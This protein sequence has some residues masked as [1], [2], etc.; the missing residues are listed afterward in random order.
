MKPDGRG[1]GVVPRGSSVRR[2]GPGDE[3]GLSERGRAA[4]DDAVR[5]ARQRDRPVDDWATDFDVLDPVYVADPFRVWD[6]LRTRCPVAHSGRRG[7]DW[8]PTRYEDVTAIAHDTEHFSSVD[9]IVIPLEVERPEEAILPF[10]FPPSPPIRL[11]TPG[12][13]GS[14]SPG[15]PT[16]EWRSTST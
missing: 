5:R 8:L 4:A 9:V 11:C 6:E 3:A 13:A 14:S 15:S 1:I 12:R 10:G 2:D 7:S 16:G